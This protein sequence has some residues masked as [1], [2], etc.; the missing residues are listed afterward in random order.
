MTPKITNKYR[1]ELASLWEEH[2]RVEFGKGL[3]A[4]EP[5]EVADWNPDA[6][7]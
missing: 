3:D 7:K 4:R 1:G 6:M 2:V 5:G